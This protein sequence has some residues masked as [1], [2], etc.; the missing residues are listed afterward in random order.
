MHKHFKYIL[1]TTAVI[2][3]IP[4][5]AML[6]TNQVQWSLLDFILAAV[7]IFGTGL[8]ISIIS[9]KVQK[10]RLRW[11]LVMLVM[12]LLAIVWIELAVGIFNSPLAGS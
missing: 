8:V 2:L 7:L 3:S 10:K 12:V 11:V 4:A 9:R 6:F 1:L 5:I